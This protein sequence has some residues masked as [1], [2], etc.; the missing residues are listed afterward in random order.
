MKCPLITGFCGGLLIVAGCTYIGY[1]GTAAIVYRQKQSTWFNSL[2]KHD[3]DRLRQ[4]GQMA[5]AYSLS[6]LSI[7][8]T[9]L[10][11]DKSIQT[12]VKIRSTAPQELWP[13]LDLRMAKDYATL[14]RLEEQAGDPAGAA[15]HRQRAADLLRS[16]GWQTVSNEVL[17]RLADKELGSRLKN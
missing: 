4:T 16:I 1:R 9:T 7:Q 12:L 17:V 11:L 13:V 6:A 5:L 8:N 3:A 15:G 14:G 10:S 2:E